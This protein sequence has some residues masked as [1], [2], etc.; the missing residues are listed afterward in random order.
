F[1]IPLLPIGAA[2]I[3]GWFALARPSRELGPQWQHFTFVS[4]FCLGL[5]I[6]VLITK[7]P[8]F[9]HLDYLAPIF[10]IV[11]AW[12]VQRLNLESRLWRSTVPFACFYILIS[13]TAFG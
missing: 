12:A 7:R 11:L 2:A 13:S 8:D 6:S 10:Y 5:L 3:F 9:V 1:T 4:A